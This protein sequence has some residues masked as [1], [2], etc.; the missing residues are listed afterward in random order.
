MR[1]SLIKHSL[2]RSLHDMEGLGGCFGY[3]HGHTFFRRRQELGVG[4]CASGENNDKIS[5]YY[6]GPEYQQCIYNKSKMV[7][8]V[9]PAL[10]TKSK[11]QRAQ[12]PK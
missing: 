9:F 4:Y 5:R 11:T 1:P 10:A 7:D 2:Q 6:C 8:V 3:D 12:R